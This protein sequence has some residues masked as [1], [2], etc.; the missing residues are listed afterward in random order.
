MA[1]KQPKYVINPGAPPLDQSAAT[2]GSCL[3]FWGI[4]SWAETA[5]GLIHDREMF[6]LAAWPQL[7]HPVRNEECELLNCQLDS[8]HTS[9]IQESDSI[10]VK[11]MF[12]PNV[13]SDFNS[14]NV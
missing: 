8:S 11:P 7:C 4:T 9:G 2:S 6:G 13:V 3:R 14:T 1:L 10:E 12:M 5:C